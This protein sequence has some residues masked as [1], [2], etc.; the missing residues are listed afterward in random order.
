ME[1]CKSSRASGEELGQHKD[2]VFE[3]LITRRECGGKTTEIGDMA[4]GSEELWG[5]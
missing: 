5:S 3:E 1:L 4:K 2:E